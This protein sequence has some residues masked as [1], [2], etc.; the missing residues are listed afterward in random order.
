[1]KTGWR[2]LVGIGPMVAWFGCAAPNEGARVMDRAAAGRAPIYTPA[3]ALVDTYWRLDEL[4]GR[5]AP[6]GSGGKE[7]HLLLQPDKPTVRGFGGCNRFSGRYAL[8]GNALSFHA[9]TSTR[10]ACA[11]GMDLEA[12]YLA[13]L[14]RV[15]TWAREGERLTLRDADGNVVARF[16]L[17]PL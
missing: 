15:A 12:E 10:M 1:M 8:D 14:G 17:R 13:A 6:L 16:T 3:D 11:E 9:M 4:N 7:A 5:P 2:I